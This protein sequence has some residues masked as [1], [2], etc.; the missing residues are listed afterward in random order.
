MCP[1]IFT[2]VSYK[3][4]WGCLVEVVKANAKPFVI[5]S[6]AANVLFYTVDMGPTTLFNNDNEGHHTNYALTQRLDKGDDHSS[7]PIFIITDGFN[8]FSTR[9]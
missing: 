3:V 8:R 4:A 7:G 1:F 2:Q 6:N 5:A 9:P